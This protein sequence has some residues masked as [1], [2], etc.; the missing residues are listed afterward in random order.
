MARL[1]QATPYTAIDGTF[2]GSMKEFYQ[3]AFENLVPELFPMVDWLKEEGR[4]QKPKPQGKYIVF[5]V[6][7]KLGSGA[8][9]RGEN[10]TLPTADSVT[11]TQGKVPYLRGIKGRIQLSAEA[12][13]V[14]SG[15]GSFTDLVQNEMDGLMTAMKYLGQAAIWGNGDGCLAKTI[16]DPGGTTAL[17]CVSSETSAGVYPGTRWLYEGMSVIGVTGLTNYNDDATWTAAAEIDSI[18]SDTAAVLSSTVTT[19]TDTLFIVEHQASD[20]TVAA[21]KALGSVT[22]DTAGSYRGPLGLTAMVDDSS[23]SGTTYAGISTTT[24]PQWKSVCSDNSGTPRSISLDLIYKLFYKMT[25]QAG[26][27]NPDVVA[28]TNTDVYRE[29]V[30]LMENQIQFKPRELK[31][32]YQHFDLMIDG[33]GINMKLDH[34]APSFI[35]FLNPNYITL[36]QKSGPT[37]ADNHGSMWRF[38]ADKD[39][40]EA[41]WRWIFQLY[42]TNRRKHAVLRDITRTIASI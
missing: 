12:F 6:Q 14:K 39:S 41:V 28:W 11:T 33:V 4:I 18:T 16:T 13:D 5:G 3:N 21:Q 23:L 29:I 35:F 26:T 10:D 7:T 34:A 20:T 36:A 42:T 2:D 27:F 24:Y 19:G 25:R 32:G 9:Y 22:I 38:V 37:L 1:V 30:D 15:P 40:Y 31:P 17:T 8:G